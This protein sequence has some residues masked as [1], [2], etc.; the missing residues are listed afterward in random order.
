MDEYDP[1]T[2]LNPKTEHMLEDFSQFIDDQADEEEDDDTDDDMSISGSGSGRKRVSSKKLTNERRQLVYETLLKES[3]EGGKLK[4]GTI[5]A[6]ASYFSISRRTV[7]RIWKQAQECWARGVPVD[8]STKFRGRVGRKRIEIDFSKLD[9]IP[10]AD[11]PMNIRSLA[12]V[13]NASKSLIH[14]RLKEGAMT[15]YLKAA[16]SPVRGEKRVVRVK[17]NFVDQGKVFFTRSLVVFIFQLKMLVH[18][19]ITRL[20]HCNCKTIVHLY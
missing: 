10:Q 6:A 19:R 18:Y 12:K 15:P 2:L 3:K 9:D 8:V 14:R 1:H 16:A 5:T 11:R 4:Q 13:L 7:L 20:V 17:L